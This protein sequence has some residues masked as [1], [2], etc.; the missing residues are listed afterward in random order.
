MK[1]L[2]NS[3]QIIGQLTDEQIDQLLEL[4]DKVKHRLQTDP[5]NYA[6]G[7]LSGWLGAKWNLKDK[8]FAEPDICS[9]RL[10]Q[11]CQSLYPGC[12]LALLTYS[13][14][15][16]AGINL[17]RDDSYASFEARSLSILESGAPTWFKYQPCYSGMSYAADSDES[18]LIFQLVIPSGGVIR[19]NCKNPHSAVPPEHRW[20]LNMWKVANKFKAAFGEPPENHYDHSMLIQPILLTGEEQVPAFR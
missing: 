10:W 5:S 11:I 9:K 7:R 6:R 19:F 15:T 20:S 2:K 12:D 3:I 14:E 4:F 18:A 17:H 16:G 13:G 8:T 1:K